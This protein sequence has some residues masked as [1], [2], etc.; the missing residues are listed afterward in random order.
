MARAMQL[1]RLDAT[2][3]TCSPKPSLAFL[4]AESVFCPQPDVRVVLHT[5]AA[6]TV[7]IMPSR[8]WMPP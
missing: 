5:L 8:L 7:E 1:L 6:E 4:Y 3:T 2:S